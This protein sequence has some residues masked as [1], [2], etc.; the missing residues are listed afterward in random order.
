MSVVAIYSR[1]LSNNHGAALH[2]AI[3]FKYKIAY[4][5]L[6]E[7]WMKLDHIGIVAKKIDD[8]I[9]NFYT[10]TIGCEKPR[11]FK[12]LSSP[13]ESVR[14]CHMDLPPNNIELLEPRSGPLLEV[15]R[16]DG[17]G[18]I[19]EVCYEVE[20]IEKFYDKM[21]RN[22]ITLV[23]STGIP[24]PE[25]VKFCQVPGDNKYAYFPRSR[26]FGTVIEVT[27]RSTW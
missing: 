8:E 6:G 27:E 13:G 7:I 25:N 12:E 19:V 4:I 2:P 20:N 17:P 3:P 26:T 15:L 9:I 21:R 22:G 16:R 18:S 24:I 5:D 14:Y 1:I 11:F 23:D 10:E